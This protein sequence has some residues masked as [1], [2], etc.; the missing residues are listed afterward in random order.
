M[1]IDF[2]TSCNRTERDIPKTS[3][4]YQNFSLFVFTQFSKKATSI[5]L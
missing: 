1:L 2:K 3:I 5:V 4:N